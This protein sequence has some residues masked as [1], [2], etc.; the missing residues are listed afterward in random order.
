M[1]FIYLVIFIFLFFAI[2]YF[3][4]HSFSSS[5]QR[6]QTLKSTILCIY[7]YPIFILSLLLFYAGIINFLFFCLKFFNGFLLFVVLEPNHLFTISYFFTIG[8]CISFLFWS[9]KKTANND[10]RYIAVF[11]KL[12]YI[13]ISFIITK[14]V[15][16]NIDYL[17]QVDFMKQETLESANIMALII[18]FII[19]MLLSF[20]P[21]LRKN[22][23][24]LI[25][26]ARV[27]IK[28]VFGYFMIISFVAAVG[29]FLKFIALIIDFL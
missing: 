18:I 17:Y 12:V 25:I 22:T 27:S 9:A 6:S 13:I 2:K 11:Y 8:L 21:Y 14:S 19:V 7:Y 16:Y 24:S 26:Y 15:W 5:L 4:N 29:L 10:F 20:L 3:V 28:I 1:L 23:S